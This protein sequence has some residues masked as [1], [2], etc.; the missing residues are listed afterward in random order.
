M[1]NVRTFQ[2]I[3]GNGARHQKIKLAFDELESM[4][5]VVESADELNE[6][7]G[8][9][10]RD[11]NGNII[12]HQTGSGVFTHSGDTA[13]MN[14]GYIYADDGT[15]IV[16][17]QNVDGHA[18]WD[19]DCHGVSFADGEYWINN[20]EVN[21]ILAGDGYSSKSNG[22]YSTG[23]VVVYYDYS[24]NVI[25]SATITSTDGSSATVYGQ[26]GL[27]VENSYSSI[28]SGYTGYGSYQV[29]GN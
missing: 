24:G 29:F 7:L 10:Q 1:K 23:D 6:Y 4:M 13:T 8:G 21:S 26:G 25:H 5:D 9:I 19:T 14:I 2:G 3:L 11:A 18:G 17:M 27:E 15:P 16:A 28:E 22:Q 12:F 20:S